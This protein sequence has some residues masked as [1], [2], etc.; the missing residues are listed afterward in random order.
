[1]CLC[2]FL[3]T[4]R[5][6]IKYSAVT[7]AQQKSDLSKAKTLLFLW[8]SRSLLPSQLP[9]QHSMPPLLTNTHF[10]PYFSL[11][12]FPRLPVPPC[13]SSGSDT[14]TKELSFGSRDLF[15][16]LKKT[17]TSYLFV[18]CAWSLLFLSAQNFQ[19]SGRFL[20]TLFSHFSVHDI[21]FLTFNTSLS[22][23]LASTMS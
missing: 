7:G 21:V 12:I 3:L 5:Y 20:E 15:F 17:T 6:H 19:S 11:S 9:A 10:S 14:V 8:Y 13:M 2:V 18:L 23:T 4:L 22:F 1:M 16:L